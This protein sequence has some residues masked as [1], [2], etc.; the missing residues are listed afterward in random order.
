[1][2]PFTL[3]NFVLH[4]VQQE[5][6]GTRRTLDAAFDF[7]NSLYADGLVCGRERTRIESRRTQD[8]RDVWDVWRVWK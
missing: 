3:G 6:M 1:M 5:L 7:A 4:D 8:G 2:K